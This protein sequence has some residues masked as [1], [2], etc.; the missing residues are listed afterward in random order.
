MYP[1]SSFMWLRLNPWFGQNEALKGEFSKLPNDMIV[2]IIS[3]LPPDALAKLV[4]GSNKRIRTIVENTPIYLELEGKKIAGTY[5]QVRKSLTQI[6]QIQHDIKTLKHASFCSNEFSDCC[7]LSSM[8]TGAFVGSGISF[9]S[10]FAA[11]TPNCISTPILFGAF[12]TPILLGTV[13]GGLFGY[14]PKLCNSQIKKERKRL[15][16]ELKQLDCD[17]VNCITIPYKRKIN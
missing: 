4:M 11:F 16:A 6:K 5:A 3:Y 7:F 8:I 12:M 13:T 2:E 14:I 9:F 17:P 15:R 1:E 10:V